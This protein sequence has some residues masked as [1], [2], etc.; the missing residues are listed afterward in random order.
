M[1][2]VAWF[3]KCYIVNLK[4]FLVWQSEEYFFDFEDA[5]SRVGGLGI[6]QG[7]RQSVFTPKHVHLAF[8]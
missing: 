3:G 6:G 1:F 8:L 7:K 2:L 4:D 5:D